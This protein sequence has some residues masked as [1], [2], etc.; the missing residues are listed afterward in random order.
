[1][2]EQRD[3]IR[4]THHAPTVDHAPD[5]ALLSLAAIAAMPWLPDADRIYVGHDD[6][7]PVYYQVVGWDATER[8]LIVEREGKR[9]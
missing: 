3:V 6:T 4:V 1:M 9:G 5:R 7:G 8:A 2:A